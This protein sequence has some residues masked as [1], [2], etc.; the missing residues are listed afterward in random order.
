[1]FSFPAKPTSSKDRCAFVV[2]EPHEDK[3]EESGGW[4]KEIVSMEF[5][6]IVPRTLLNKRQNASLGRQEGE[7]QS[8]PVETK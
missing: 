8:C 2:G 4:E 7:W 6:T 3:F 5:R 1:M